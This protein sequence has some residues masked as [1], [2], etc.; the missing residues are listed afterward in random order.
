M[1]KHIRVMKEPKDI[2]V[3]VTKLEQACNV[4]DEDALPLFLWLL[5]LL[6]AFGLE[7][8]RNA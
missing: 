1:T 7:S 2:S 5:L 4:T 3:I 8:R 6:W